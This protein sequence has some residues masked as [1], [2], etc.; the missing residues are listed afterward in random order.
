MVNKIQTVVCGPAGDIELT[1]DLPNQP[2]N[3]A[4]LCH[5]HPL[6]G[7]SMHDGVLQIA[8]DALL[9]QDLGVVRFNFRGVG[10]SQGISG[11]TTEDE[12]AT[13]SYT[14]PEVGDLMAVVR[15][16]ANEHGAN[17]PL[18]VGYSYGAHVV[19]HA[20]PLLTTQQA[21]LIAPPTAAMPFQHIEFSTRDRIHAVWC[22][23][24]D[25]VDSHFFADNPKVQSLTLNGGGHFFAGQ[26][27]NLASAV[28]STLTR[29]LIRE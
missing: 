2:S 19:W 27:E 25:F 4:V 1:L 21:L 24:D 11:K 23:D 26:A 28:V 3:I 5:P 14:P 13:A 6:Y 12:K 22:D 16:L 15:W 9:H 29:G 17:A 18:C 8:A 20:L 10:A 7:G